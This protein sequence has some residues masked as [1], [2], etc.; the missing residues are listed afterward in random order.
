MWQWF[1]MERM[2]RGMMK[3]WHCCANFVL[4]SLRVV[5][6]LSCP[7]VYLVDQ[8][9]AYG[10]SSTKRCESIHHNKAARLGAYK[11]MIVLL[12]YSIISNVLL[13]NQR[14]SKA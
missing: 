5:T 3:P 8:S 1:Y 4:L 13:S 10:S 9:L 14:I 12:V 7:S 11:L 2:K 6:S